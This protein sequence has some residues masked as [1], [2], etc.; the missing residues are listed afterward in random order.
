M[1]DA[2]QYSHLPGSLRATCRSWR[3]REGF[4]IREDAPA[5]SRLN[6]RGCARNGSAQSGRMRPE[7]PRSILGAP[8][9]F[10]YSPHDAGPYRATWTPVARLR[11][12]TEREPTGSREDAP[13]GFASV[14]IRLAIGMAIRDLRGSARESRPMFA[15]APGCRSNHD[16][17]VG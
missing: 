2:F 5:D 9:G 10:R 12:G 14:P 4:R 6:P 3:F 13:G 16:P 11:H 17:S 15:D 8:S 7:A 1:V